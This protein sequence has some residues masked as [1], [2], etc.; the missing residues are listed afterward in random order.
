MTQWHI[1][2]FLW[3]NTLRTICLGEMKA[4]WEYNHTKGIGSVLVSVS[5]SPRLRS[6]LLPTSFTSLEKQCKFREPK[7]P[8]HANHRIILKGFLKC[9]TP[10]KRITPVK[11]LRD[12]LM[13]GVVWDEGVICGLVSGVWPQQSHW[14]LVS[15]YCLGFCFVFFF[16]KFWALIICCCLCLGRRIITWLKH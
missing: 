11:W 7:S 14:C 9:S 13:L 1:K 12:D 10:Q 8:K 15:F 4:Q 3:T 16:F 6:G 2:G 5:F